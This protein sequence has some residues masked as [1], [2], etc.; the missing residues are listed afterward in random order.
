VHGS[1]RSHGL[2]V[3]QTVKVLVSMGDIATVNTRLIIP[4][5]AGGSCWTNPCR[6]KSKEAE[7]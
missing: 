1:S 5:D 4:V 2:E 6:M 3:Q 7:E